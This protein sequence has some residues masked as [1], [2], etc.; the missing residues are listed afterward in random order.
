MSGAIAMIRDSAAA[1]APRGG[2]LGRVRGLRF[3]ASGWDPAV[4]RRM[5]A[6]GWIGLRVPEAAGGSGLGLLEQ[7]ALLEELGRGLVP[8]PLVH[9]AMAAAV[10]AA[11]GDTVLLPRLLSGEVFVPL[12][13][14][15]AADA[16]D[17]P[18]TREGVRRFV[19]LPPAA[20][21]V[22]VPVREGGG[23]ALFEAVL[24]GASA[25]GTQDGGRV[26]TWAPELRNA[27]RI[28][29]IDDGLG[30]ALEDAALG[31]AF[32]LLGVA[33]AAFGMTLDYLRTREQ[34]GRKLG[35]FQALQHRAADLKI[36][37][38][39]TRASVEAAAAS[40][41][42]GASG[43]ARSGA[44]AR[45]KVRAAV[46]AMEVTRAA[47]QL[48]GAIGYTDEYD[49]GLYLRRAMVVANEYGSARAWRRRFAESAEGGEGGAQHA[50]D[51]E[52]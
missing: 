39:L 52:A 4:W 49:V 10:L 6:L 46:T 42:A 27:R 15:E 41:D 45:A 38:A 31:T 13:W 32:Y 28:G 14:Q 35:S 24:T 19:V 30:P 50:G 12:A 2:G 34:F 16:T 8:E 3:Q 20:G 23:V 22:L 11:A 25:A 21:P 47:V 37:L 51:D 7:G 9:G 40:L 44:V 5:G 48:H 26:G 18:G 17:A 36:G 43:P 1:V 29:A 33:E